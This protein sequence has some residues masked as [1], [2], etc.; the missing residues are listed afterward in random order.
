MNDQ[1]TQATIADL[2]D[3]VASRYGQIGQILLPTQDNGWSSVLGSR[4][5]PEW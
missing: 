5:E 4:K 2:Y 1:E 3:R